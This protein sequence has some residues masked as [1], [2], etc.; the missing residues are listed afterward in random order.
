MS[1]AMHVSRSSTFLLGVADSI[2]P[3]HVIH[4]ARIYGGGVRQRFVG[5]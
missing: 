4:E 3:G 2:R 1:G 5:L